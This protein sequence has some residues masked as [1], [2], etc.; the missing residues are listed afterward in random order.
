MN[1]ENNKTE[2]TGEYGNVIE[3]TYRE[4]E[5]DY[6][7][8]ESEVTPQAEDNVNETQSSQSQSAATQEDGT[9]SYSYRRNEAGAT[10]SGDYYAGQYQ[11]Q[12][13]QNQQYQNSQYQNQQ[14]QNQQYQNQ[15]YQKPVTPK[16]QKKEFSFGKKLLVTVACAL[17]FGIV[18]GVCFNGV[19][20]LFG[21][22]QEV[23]QNNG[24]ML[25][26]TT[27]NSSTNSKGTT[28]NTGDGDVTAIVEQT[29]PAIVAITS[30]TKG[31]NYYDL[32]GREYEGQESTSAGT[33]F[34]IGQNNKELL[35]ATNNHVV[36]GAKT[37]SIQFIDGEVYEATEKGADSANDLAVVAVKTS[38]IKQETMDQIKIADMGSSD[39]I[40][41]GEKVVAIGNA[42]GYGQS[43]TVG[44]I[45]AKDREISEASSDGTGSPNTIKALQTDAAINPGN[46]GGALINMQGQVIGINSAKIASSTVEGVGYA[47]PISVA[48]PIIDELVNRESLSDDE[49]GYLGISG[50]TVTESANAYNLPYGVYVKE[51]SKDSAAEEAGIKVGDVITAVNKMEVTTME[52]LKEKV[53]SYRVGTKITLTIKR[54]SDGEYKEKKI[55]VT[56]KG[57]DSLDGLEDSDSQ[58]DTDKRYNDYDEGNDS[59]DS[60][61]FFGGN[62][63]FGY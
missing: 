27:T 18:A 61:G 29:M 30:T 44:Y 63:F 38:S 19:N 15:Q 62:G 20:Y 32:F 34:I 39:D 40:K 11:N 9:Y 48:T 5:P 6:A 28:N 2:Y 58:E 43:V 21:T 45:S 57:K 49:R 16:K 42:L 22:K 7:Q 54:S 35:I 13:P 33:G 31:A 55:T 25:S 8:Q 23:S 59:D 10:H 4:T 41:V 51:V 47:I 36:S 53:N 50:A 26:K 52:S 12:Q 60:N 56:L 17:V 24:A 14:Y 3:G 46:S 1:E 37:I